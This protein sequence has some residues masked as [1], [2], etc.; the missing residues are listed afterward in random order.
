[1]FL[2][3]RF[4]KQ[5]NSIKPPPAPQVEVKREKHIYPKNF[6]VRFELSQ[7]SGSITN[8]DTTSE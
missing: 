3:Y 7:H 5:F 1:V 4:R 8:K 2:I 6:R